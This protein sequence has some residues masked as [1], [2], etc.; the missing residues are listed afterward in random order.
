MEV[1]PE[2]SDVARIKTKKLAKMAKKMGQVQQ[3]LSCQY[4]AAE[5]ELTRRGRASRAP[6]AAPEPAKADPALLRDDPLLQRLGGLEAK[7]SR[8]QGDLA[9]KDKQLQKAQKAIRR[10]EKQPAAGPLPV[11][12]PASLERSFTAND[13]EAD[14][15]GEDAAALKSRY[16]ALLD[17]AQ[18]EQDSGKRQ[19]A[20]TEIGLLAAQLSEAGVSV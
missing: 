16:D 20:A 5:A 2:G 11:R 13:R 10:V 18:K 12:F 1:L 6:I 14:G 3:A 9:A 15:G 7:I 8:L 19:Q 4:R 17:S